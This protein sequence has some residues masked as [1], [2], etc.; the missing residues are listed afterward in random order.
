MRVTWSA[1]I[2]VGMF[3]VLAGCSETTLSPSGQPVQVSLWDCQRGFRNPTTG[4]VQSLTPDA[5]L[6]AGTESQ[7]EAACVAAINATAPAGFVA[8]CSCS[9]SQ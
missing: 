4:A 1:V 7:A 8:Q 2:G 3:L 9:L 5:T 6:D